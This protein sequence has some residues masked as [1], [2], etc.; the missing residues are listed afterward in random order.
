MFTLGWIFGLL[1]HRGKSREMKTHKYL[2]SKNEGNQYRS[3]NTNISQLLKK[4]KEQENGE[5]RKNIYMA[6]AAIS[7][8]ALSGFIISQ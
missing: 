8:L 3:T 4:A 5:K 7:V 2:I 1:I 6:A